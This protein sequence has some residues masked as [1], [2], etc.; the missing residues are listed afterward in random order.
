MPSIDLAE[1][2]LH[3]SASQ[4]K[5]CSQN[6]RNLRQQSQAT[7]NPKKITI[8]LQGFGAH[9]LKNPATKMLSWMS[10]FPYIKELVFHFQI[11]RKTPPGAK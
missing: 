11:I 10:I 6:L 5:L 2:C 9:T 4:P 3:L 1:E 7:S 8:D